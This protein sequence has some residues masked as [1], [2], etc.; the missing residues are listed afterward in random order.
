MHGKPPPGRPFD[1]VESDIREIT[2]I[3][4]V[5]SAMIRRIDEVA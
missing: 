1:R 3:R 5:L 2:G 4:N